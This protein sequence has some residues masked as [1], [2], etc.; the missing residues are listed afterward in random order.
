MAIIPAVEAVHVPAHFEP[1]VCPQAKQ[2]LHHHAQLSLRQS[3][4]RKKIFCIYAHRVASVEFNSLRPCR[5]WPA[6]L[7]CQGEGFCRQEYWSL[8]ATTCCHTLLE[9]YIS[10]CPSCQLSRVPGAARTPETQAVGPPRHLDLTGANPSPPRKPQ[11]QTSVD[12]THAEVVIKSQLKPISSVA[13]EEDPKPS[14]QLYK[15]KIKPTQSTR[16][17][18]SMEYIKGH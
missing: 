2:L 18:V 9:H 3:C 8:L 1:P 5:L 7:L 4:H 17:T 6:M 11:E 14:H 12:D 15:L 10:C 13:K 16:Q